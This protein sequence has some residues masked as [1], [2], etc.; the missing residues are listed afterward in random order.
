MDKTIKKALMQFLE[1]HHLLS[2]AQHDF[3]SGR[4]C[5]TN[6]LF[7]LERWTK[8]RDEDSVVHAI[9]I[10]FK[11]AFDGVPHQRLLHKMRNVGIR[12]R[13]PVDKREEWQRIAKSNILIGTPGRFAQHQMENPTLDMSNLRILVLDEA[14]RLMDPT[15]RHDLQSIIDN[16]ATDRQCLLY[17]ATLVKSP[18]QL[19]FLNLK[20]PI[21]ISTNSSVAPFRWRGSWMCS[22]PFFRVTQQQ[23]PE[24]RIK[25]VLSNRAPL[26]LASQ[27]EL[28]AS[29]RS[30]FSAYLRDYCFT[31]KQTNASNKTPDMSLVFRPTELPIAKFAASL[32][33]AVTPELPKLFQ[34][35]LSEAGVDPPS[36]PAEVP[37]DIRSSAL[38][39]FAG[40]GEDDDDDDGLLKRK[41]FSAL[42]ANPELKARLESRGGKLLEVASSSDDDEENDDQDV[43]Q[44]E[45]T[46]APHRAVPDTMVKHVKQPLSRIQ[47]A[48]RELKKNIRSH[49]KIQFDE[50]GNPL[51]KTVGGVPVPD[52]PHSVSERVEQPVEEDKVEE[53][54]EEEESLPVRRLDVQD[55]RRQLKTIVDAQDKA[56]WRER[57][58]Q[59]H[60]LERQKA[61]EARK[62]QQAHL[63]SAANPSLGSSSSQS[64]QSDAPEES[65]GDESDSEV[66]SPPSPPASKRARKR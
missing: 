17:S 6:L 42:D 44:A 8:A 27:P 25:P 48:K 37:A 21:M 7:T 57:V 5:L 26:L 39:S 56:R 33:L 62:A 23:I 11:K 40:E 51:L 52:L 55:A 47:M 4:S 1:Q 2:D 66:V 16:L 49:S 3:R 15:F 10:D 50:S 34:Q 43:G 38:W 46:V 59:K 61:R 58:R 65:E 22:G 19:E 31:R 29:A 36:R 54:E 45:S 63:V 24:S 32:G 9:Y 14:D 13:L 64:D 20:S 28:A 35:R 18:D 30:A 41:A 53:W 60:R 12:G